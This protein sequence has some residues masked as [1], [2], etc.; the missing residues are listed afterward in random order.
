VTRRA[1]ETGGGEQ[2][3]RL[4]ALAAV[5]RHFDATWPPAFDALTEG[6]SVW[7]CMPWLNLASGKNGWPTDCVSVVHGPSNQGKTSFVLA[8]L[9]SFLEQECP[10]VLLDI[11]QT[12][13]FSFA[14]SMMGDC[15]RLPIFRAS[16]QASYETTRNEV[17]RFCDVIGE[18]RAKKAVPENTTALIAIDSLKKL[19]PDK[20]WDALDKEVGKP[21]RGR[22]GKEEVQYGIDGMNGAAGRFKAAFNGAWLDELGPLL[23]QTGVGMVIIAREKVEKTMFGENVTL[24]GGNN[25]FFDSAFVTRIVCKRQIVDSEG[26][27]GATLYGEQHEVEVYKTKIAG[28]RTRWPTAY[29]HTST[30]ALDG[31]PLGFDAAR[32]YLETAKHLELIDPKDAYN[33]FEGEKLGHGANQAVKRLYADAKVFA[34]LRAVVDEVVASRC[35]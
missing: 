27:A 20:L 8:L 12:T 26:G 24:G 14:A 31:V 15:A 19:L 18:A 35:S 21:K 10:A 32:D 33:A 7:T 1:K 13:A 4:A 9:K 28:K 5:A 2:Q 23:K 25:L 29:F 16:R 17:R 22:D 11:E 3:S 6:R 30:G 34:R